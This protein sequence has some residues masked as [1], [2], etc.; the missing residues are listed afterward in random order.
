[1]FEPI[2]SWATGAARGVSQADS[3]VVPGSPGGSGVVSAN[4]AMAEPATKSKYIAQPFASVVDAQ[5]GRYEVAAGVL[6]RI[7]KPVKSF[8]KV[9][10]LV[11]DVNRTRMWCEA[12]VG[13]HG[14]MDAL[15]KKLQPGQL[16]A[17]RGLQFKRSQYHSGGKFLDLGKKQKVIVDAL[18]P[19]HAGRADLLRVLKKG[20]ST[21]GDI[22]GLEGLSKGNKADLVCKICS[23]NHRILKEAQEKTEMWVKDTSNKRLLVEAW[24]KTFATQLQGLSPEA[25]VCLMN[26]SVKGDASDSV[27]LTGE[28][29]GQSE[30]GSAFVVVVEDS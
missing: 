4:R 23:I 1:M 5:S 14:E 10:A 19:T 2:L 9:V 8:Y 28:H 12:A 18:P 26:F 29:A 7:M 30:K 17:F 16:F 13:S 27:I 15:Q 22:S 3:G 11:M 24:G 25:V 20:P 21:Q 6:M